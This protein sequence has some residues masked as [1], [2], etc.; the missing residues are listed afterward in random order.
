MMKNAK[1]QSKEERKNKWEKKG[2][3]G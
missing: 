2:S 1:K 3:A